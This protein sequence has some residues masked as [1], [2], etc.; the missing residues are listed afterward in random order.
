MDLGSG[1]QG[2]FYYVPDDAFGVLANFGDLDFEAGSG[3]GDGFE[4]AGVAGGEGG[5]VERE[6]PGAG[7]ACAGL[8]ADVSY[9]GGEVF[10][11]A[12]ARFVAIAAVKASISVLL[13][14]MK[15]VR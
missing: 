7:E 5:V 12:A 15:G 11:S 10:Q 2:L 13:P 4:D 8:E 9:G 1:G 6:E 3:A 14:T